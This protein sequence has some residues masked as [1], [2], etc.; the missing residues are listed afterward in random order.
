[1]S[2]L[3]TSA[4]LSLL[5]VLAVWLT[6]RRDPA[7]SPLLTLGSLLTLLALPFLAQLP[8]LM[9]EL[10]ALTA[11]AQPGAVSATISWFPLLWMG[12]FLLFTL[13]LAADFVSLNRWRARSV[14]AGKPLM[15]RT[16]ENCRLQLGLRH[17]IRVR[18]HPQCMSPFIAG[19]FRPVVYLPSSSVHWN[20]GTLRMVLLHE[21]GHVARRDLWTNLAAQC[22]CLV[23]W[24]NPLVWWLRSRLMAQ[25]EFA[26]DAK[27]IALG[28]DPDR[29]ATALCDIAEAGTLPQAALAMAG[30][31]PLRAR[32]ERV[33]C[34]RRAK[35]SLLVGATLLFTVSASLGLSVVRL[36]PARLTLAA[37]SGHRA[38]HLSSLSLA[39]E[40]NLRSSANPFPAD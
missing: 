36:S 11:P 3:L 39:E 19:L 21:L 31:A 33:V 9:V 32:V 23:Y 15:E 18:L 29:Y 22:A 6:G 13:R 17:R 30:R 20:E 10:P 12:G 25:C 7:Q 35:H 14:D 28:T 26:C 24:F 2:L 5:A 38:D 1:M 4:A 37:D 34:R 40:I 27:V 16:L 8:K